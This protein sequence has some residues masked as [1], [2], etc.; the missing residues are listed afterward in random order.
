MWDSR[1]QLSRNGEAEQ[2]AFWRPTSF[3]V[4]ADAAAG[5]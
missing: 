5:P 3:S 4:S 2:L 1:H